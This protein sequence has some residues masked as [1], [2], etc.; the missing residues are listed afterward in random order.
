MPKI[1]YQASPKN[2][3]VQLSLVDAWKMSILTSSHMKNF[4]HRVGFD[5]AIGQ[6]RSRHIWIV[7]GRGVILRTLKGRN[8]EKR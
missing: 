1:I 6:L 3:P 4:F 7:E 8:H 2:S 5:R